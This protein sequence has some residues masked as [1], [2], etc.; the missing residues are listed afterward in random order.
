MLPTTS[1][2][3]PKIARIW[4]KSQNAA[5]Q[6]LLFVLFVCGLLAYA[7]AFAWHILT[8]FDLVNI[9]RDVNTEDS[10]YY[11]QIAYNLAQ[12]KFSTFDGGITQTNG[13]HPVWLLLI[14]PFLL[15]IR[16]RNG[17]VRHQ[18]V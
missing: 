1:T 9:L 11:F 10:F 3:K 6:R 13:Y 15:A 4:A 2:W 16:Q 8:T 12:G 18:G 7:A 5:A 14:T 17:A